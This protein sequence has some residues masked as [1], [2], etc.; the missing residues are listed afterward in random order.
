MGRSGKLW[1]TLIGGRAIREGKTKTSSVYGAERFNFCRL[2][3]LLPLPP[4]SPHKCKPYRPG[5]RSSRVLTRRARQHLLDSLVNLHI[6]S[7][8]Q[9]EAAYTR[10]HPL[11]QHPPKPA[12]CSATR[13]TPLTTPCQH[14]PT[15]AHN[16]RVQLCCSKPSKAALHRLDTEYKVRT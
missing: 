10:L 7:P 15:V 6:G 14:R 11:C 16:D 3:S 2:S 8:H 1:S 9:P 13:L 12:A 5:C 4:N